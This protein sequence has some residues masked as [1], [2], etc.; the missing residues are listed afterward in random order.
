M[1]VNDYDEKLQM[2]LKWAGKNERHKTDIM[3]WENHVATNTDIF[4]ES[5]ISNG[6][7]CMALMSHHLMQSWPK[8]RA[9]RIMPEYEMKEKRILTTS[10][11]L[12]MV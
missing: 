7:L 9:I 3:E 5:T 8:Y 10:L 4:A 2:T 11:S 1:E 12:S 6:V